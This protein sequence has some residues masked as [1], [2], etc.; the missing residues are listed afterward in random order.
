MNDDDGDI[1]R[2]SF[3][4]SSF[5]FAHTHTHFIHDTELKNK[6]NIITLTTWPSNIHISKLYHAIQNDWFLPE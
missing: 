6:Q 2:T 1:R 5:S 3:I 4:Y